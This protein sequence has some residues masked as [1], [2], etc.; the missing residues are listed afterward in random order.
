MRKE[1][2][3]AADILIDS[4]KNNTLCI[5]FSNYLRKGFALFIT[6]GV[7]RKVEE[8]LENEN[9]TKTWHT[10]LKEA[11]QQRLIVKSRH[12]YKLNREFKKLYRS[13]PTRGEKLTLVERELI[14]FSFQQ[15]VEIDTNDPRIINVINE[16]KSNPRYRKYTLK[17][18]SR[19][20]NQTSD[21]KSTV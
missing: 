4:L 7:R 12:K 13:L 19:R 21:G 11:L 8:S 3:V 17:L 18:Y 15:G 6:F 5:Y 9:E 14:A 2:A 1:I 20:Y 10:L 16:I